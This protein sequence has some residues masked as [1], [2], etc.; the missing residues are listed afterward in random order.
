MIE[1]VNRVLDGACGSACIGRRRPAHHNDLDAE[2]AR[3]CDLA[4]S[5][6]AA[7]VLGNNNIDPVRRYERAIVGFAKRPARRNVSDVRQ[8]QRR[9]DRID[10]ADQINV[11]RRRAERRQLV[12]AQR[13]KDI[14]AVLAERMHRGAGVVDLDPAVTRHGIPWR[15]V[16][17]Q[18]SDAGRARSRRRI[19]RNRRRIGM[20]GVDQSIHALGGKMR[21]Q[22]LGPAETADPHRDGMRNR[23][24]GAAGERQGHVKPV[25]PREALAQ[26]ARLR[27]AAKNQDAWHG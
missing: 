2:R 7:A 25:A 5:G 6:A 8:R 12:A 10:A 11:L 13:H 22:A 20:R 24:G 26:Q 18:K 17:Y 9:I 21:G 23:R 19:S 16:Q 14:A 1:P 4:I 15:P 27:G 3:G